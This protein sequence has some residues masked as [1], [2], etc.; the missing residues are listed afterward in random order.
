MGVLELI[1]E[2]VRK[3]MWGGGKVE[4]QIRE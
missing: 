3:M 1:L 4:R 2:F